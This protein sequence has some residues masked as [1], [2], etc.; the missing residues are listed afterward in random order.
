[1][2][3]AGSVPP[4]DAFITRKLREAGAIVLGKATLTEFANFIALAMPAGYSGLGLYGFNLYDPRVL[5]GGDGRPVL[6]PGGSARGPASPSTPTSRPSQ[7]VRKRP[8]RFSVRRPP[9]ASSGSNRRSVLSAGAASF[10]SRPIR[11]R[12]VR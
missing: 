5:P 6:T 3:L 11:I 4:N 12:R 2:T 7:S 1:M 9:T 8:D 10:R